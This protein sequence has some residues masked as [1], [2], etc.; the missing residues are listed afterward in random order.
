VGT[1]RAGW[2]EVLKAAGE[3]ADS[4][5]T[6]LPA[7][8]DRRPRVRRAVFRR[9]PPAVL[10][11]VVL[12]ATAAMT[13]AAA[14]AA[15]VPATPALG[16]AAAAAPASAGGPISVLGRVVH[17]DDGDTVD[18]D[19]WGD[20]TRTP[21]RVRM[22]GVNAMELT[23][24]ANNPRDWRGDCHGVAAAR[25]LYGLVYGK[26]VRLTAQNAGS[27]SGT[28][29]RR[30]VWIPSGHGWRNVST[31]LLAEGHGLF[32]PNGTEYA[33][34]RTA[35][36]AAQ[37]AARRGR[38]LWNTDA[39]GS[40]P[41]QKA[42]LR[43]QVRWDAPGDDAANPNGEYIKVS[44]HSPY[45]VD[46]SGWRVRDSAARGYK[47]H[48]FVFSRGTRLPAGGAVFVHPGSGRDT[49]T[50]LHWR[51]GAPIFENATGAP[52]YMGDGGYLFD[53]QGDLRAWQQ[54]PCRY[55]C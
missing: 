18:V 12:A 10:A 26:T 42:D 30:T 34:N 24:Y 27:K 22:T 3:P 20:G 54:Y 35:A 50:H 33:T 32:L 41:A 4:N 21:V 9:E 43:V 1:P 51:L 28:R 11:A 14:S 48:G 6:R 29:Y 53:P 13:A 5:G 38:G 16:T 7:H 36:Y 15:P 2:L 39:C 37:Y 44:N 46:L 19:V 23:R 31:I 25:R 8:S 52:T 49:A 17:V 55:S 45:A 47:Q 40:G